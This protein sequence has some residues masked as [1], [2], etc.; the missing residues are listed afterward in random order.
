MTGNRFK[1]DIL[2]R[3]KAHRILHPGMEQ[4]DTVKFVFQAMLGPE[5]L[6]SARERMTCRIAYE[7]EGLSGNPEEPLFEEISP[8]W[9]RLNL[10]RAKKE[11]ITPSVIAGLMAA[12]HADLCF[13]RQDVFDFCDR[14]AESEEWGISDGGA[15]KS[16]LDETWLPSHSS[17]YRERYHPAYRIVS[18]DWIPRME[19]IR[20]IAEKQATE[21]RPLI[22]IDGPCASGKTTLADRIAY[23][24]DAAVVHTDDFVI[25]YAQKTSE[26]LAIPGGNCDAARLAREVV[27]PWKRDDPVKYRRYDCG[28][29]RLLP[30]EELPDSG[31]LILEGSYSNLPAIREYADLCL[32]VDAPEEVRM[33]RLRKRESEESLIRFEEKWIPLENAYFEAYKLPDGRCLIV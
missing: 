23:V 13:T 27:A 4:E 6:L 31:M 19:A 8:S 30:E 25:P 11:Q 10:R 5:H 20:K 24:F 26:R 28:K 18:S 12:S 21:E 22:T 2:R 17:A 1:Q 14:L 16:I 3:L 33:D 9:S 32:F 7:M 29:D 15:L